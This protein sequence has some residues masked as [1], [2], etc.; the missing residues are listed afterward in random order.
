MLSPDD[1]D[2]V[3]DAV[4]NAN[5]L[6]IPTGS[7]TPIAHV[8]LRFQDLIEKLESYIDERDFSM[9]AMFED[10]EDEIL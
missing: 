1:A 3:Q 10:F 4:K 8:H 2:I 5:N 7:F 6:R 9:V